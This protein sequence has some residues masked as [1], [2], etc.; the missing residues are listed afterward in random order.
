V[1]FLPDGGEGS[2]RESGAFDDE[3][4]APQSYGGLQGEHNP[5][6]NPLNFR[7]ELFKQPEP[8]LLTGLNGR[9]TNLRLNYELLADQPTTN[10]IGEDSRR[11]RASVNL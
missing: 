3:E 6:R 2:R 5:G 11:L 9:R 1:D 8:A 7:G 10:G 4:T